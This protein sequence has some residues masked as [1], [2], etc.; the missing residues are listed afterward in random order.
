MTETLISASLQLLF[1]RIASQD[2]INLL[3]GRND[4]DR[5]LKKLKAT[6]GALEAVVNDAEDKQFTSRA[7]KDWLDELKDSVYHADDL[8]DEIATEALQSKL[9]AAESSKGSRNQVRHIV[10]KL[11]SPF[12]EGIESRLEEIID[13]L[14]DFVKQ[15]DILGLKGDVERKHSQRQQTTSLV[16]EIGVVYGR[17]D[18]IEKIINL[19]LSDEVVTSND[20]EIPVIPIVGMGGVGKTTLAQVAYNDARVIQSFKIKAW[21]CVSDEFD[22]SMVTKKIV[23]A[24]TASSSDTGDLN[25]LQIK[26]KE[27][28]KGNRFLLVLDDVW[29]ENYNDWDLLRRPFSTGERGS[30]IIVTTRH[31]NVARVMCSVPSHHLDQL[32]FKDSWSLFAKHAIQNGYFTTHPDLEMIGKEIVVRCKGLPLAVKSLG[33]L[34]RSKLDIEEWK[35]ILESEMWHTQS[36]I[37]PALRLSYHYL[38]SHLKRCFAYC[39]I[40][41]KDHKFE[42][43]KLVQLWIAEGFVLRHPKGNKSLEDEG[44]NYF[45]ELLSRSFFQQLS[46]TSSFFVM[47]DLIHDLA[48]FISGEF[49]FRLE[50]DHD[51][52]RDLSKKVRHFSVV[53]GKYDTIEK[54][55]VVNKAKYVRTFISFSQWKGNFLSKKVLHDILPS[56]R[57]LRVLCLRG[58]EIFELPQTI[59]K[60]IHLRHM[61][62]SNTRLKRLPD[63]ISTLCNLQTLNL[64]GC[65]DLIELPTDIGKLINLLHLNVAF[66]KLTKLPAGMRELINLHSLDTRGTT[67]TEMPMQMSRLVGLRHLTYFVVGRDSGSRISEL[68]AL[69]HLHGELSISELQNVVNC[70]DALEANFKD[71]KHLEGLKLE[72]SGNTRASQNESDVLDNLKPHTNLK[73][74]TIKGFGGR[75]LPGWLGD[76]CF[77]NI[78]RLHLSNCEYCVCLPP[79]G[80]LLSLKHLSVHGMKEV[81]KVGEEFYG[82]ASLFK[83]FQSL[84]TLH[85][86][87]MA[88]WEE[89]RHVLGADEFL[90]LLE[91]SLFRCPKLRGE[92]PNNIPCLR[93]LRISECQQLESNGVGLQLQH[94]SSL[95]QLKISDMSNLRQL[96]SELQN[97]C[98]L[99]EL[100]IS[101]MMQLPSELNQLHSLKKLTISKMP[102]LEELPL[103]LW[104]LINLEKLQI[105]QCSSLV[106]FPDFTL[107]PILKTLEI[108]NCYAVQ[109]L[110]LEMMRFNSCLQDL[111]I[112][113]CSSLVSFPVGKL[114][115][116]YISDCEKLEFPMHNEMEPCSTSFERLHISNSC[117]SLETL[118]LRFFPKLL[119]L[120]I[121]S[122]HTMVSFPH[123]GLSAP[124]LKF[125]T[126]EFCRKLKSLPQRMNT[127]LQSLQSLKIR[128]CP[129]VE[130]F[131]DGGLPSNLREL[132]IENCE[133]LMK[134]RVEWGLHRLPC[135]E[136]FTTN[137]EYREE[138]LESFPEEGL[139]PATL[140]SLYVWFLPNLK[141]L[142]YKGL[143]RLT[144][145]TSLHIW[146]CP[147]VQ[148]LPEEWLPNSLS[149]LHIRNCPLLKQRYQGQK[150]KY[151]S[152]IA[153]IRHIKL[154]NED[155]LN[156]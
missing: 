91:L 117:N 24:V 5:L 30:R 17:D 4:G 94:L 100:E 50:D 124:N 20:H 85:F 138:V 52:V 144:S 58:Y 60:L 23:E 69:Y 2:F 122:C 99:Q 155:I 77:S 9:K 61:D 106:S 38:P 15:K 97:L 90:C 103:E 153:K 146:S 7:V 28:L 101:N 21:V 19:L 75:R 150:G 67:L 49:C 113:G 102:N 10:S 125:L 37:L 98:S 18:D 142:N 84:E 48:E 43:E 16:D 70:R 118:P 93:T 46:G 62:L 31:E 116:I 47:H 152:K 140:S 29:N 107:L 149:F 6:L 44:F 27:R 71:K 79:L 25:L 42:K 151:L 143:Q 35:N 112:I 95:R 11:A 55:N 129:E 53:Q 89:W 126:V 65:G 131:P 34:L 135:L 66:T 88:K 110:P 114:K 13:T 73:Y 119:S 108:K 63:L 141:A 72:W 40:F 45:S 156:F 36:N 12:H 68:R 148:C 83:P 8:L 14:D 3:S 145:L 1:D 109:S 59:D 87:N 41:L 33:G 76:F 137:G 139:F 133:K 128:D 78:V 51:K 80:R 54:L 57:C 132:E 56:L 26:L 32:S 154:D 111:S 81:R 64:S 120:N 130:A 104:R 39:S 115:N 105:E 74:V 82:N 92:L 22:V 136:L 134:R 127:K 86:E 123:G 147:K 121:S 96:S